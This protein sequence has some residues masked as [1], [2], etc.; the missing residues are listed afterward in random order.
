MLRS[1]V[2]LSCALSLSSGNDRADWQLSPILAPGLEFVYTGSYVE[3]SLVPNVQHQRHYRLEANVLVLDAGVKDWHVA[4]MTTLNLQEA[5]QLSDKKVGPASVRL[6]LA[7]I[8]LQGRV[9][10]HDKKLVE[11]SLNGPPTFETGFI[12]P[13]PLGKVGRNSSW[14]V[15][16]EGQPPQRWQVAGTEVC[17]GVT[18]VKLIGSQQSADWDKPR[19]DQ[20]AW[21]RRDTLWLHPQHNVAQKVE[22]IIERRDPARDTPTFRTVVRYELDSRLNYPRILFEERRTEALKA[23]KF[24]EEALPLLRQP[25]QQRQQIDNMIQRVSF[26]LDHQNATQAPYRKAVVHL[27][28]ALEKAQKGEAAVPVENDPPPPASKALGIGERVTDFAVSSLTDDKVAQFKQYQG[29]PMIVFFYNPATPLGK[30]VLTYVKRLH[31]KQATPFGVMALAVTN[32]G[33]LVR[34]QH[35]DMKLAFP[36]L[37]GNG[38]RLMLGAEQTPRFVIVDGDGLVR[39]AETGWGFHTPFEIEKTLQSLKR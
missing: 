20:T 12:A 14:E 37:D 8:D 22:R 3:E 31:D 30:E 4:V 32:D 2:V 34:K 13:T 39:L 15:G 23:S 5:R 7:K 35:Q 24:Q 21:R 27:R 38:L 36:I 17:A 9:R 6:D 18:C 33:D 1:I 29:K 10:N 11:L 25:A 16:E 26:H 28:G 19:A